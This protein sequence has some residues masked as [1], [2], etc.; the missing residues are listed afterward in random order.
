MS[1]LPSVELQ[2]LIHAWHLVDVQ[3]ILLKYFIA[4]EGLSAVPP[5]P[6]K[7]NISPRGQL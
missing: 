6:L 1:V 4:E 5:S 7:V 3:Y 2:D